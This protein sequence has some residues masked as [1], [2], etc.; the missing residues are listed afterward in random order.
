MLKE[1]EILAEQS[2]LSV[3]F[4]I[5]AL[6]VLFVWTLFWKGLALWHS[7]KK[8]HTWW[9]II[10]LIVNTVGIL[11]I[12]YLTLIAKVKPKDWFRK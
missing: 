2:G 12:I 10:F 4:I 9:F 3:N 11:E 8:G 5:G 6:L 1:I 7:V